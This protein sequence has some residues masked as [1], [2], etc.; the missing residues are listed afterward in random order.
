MGLA[1]SPRKPAQTEKRGPRQRPARRLTAAPRPSGCLSKA[2]A[3]AGPTHVPTS[4]YFQTW[5]THHPLVLC[6]WGSRPELTEKP[7][8][9]LLLQDHS[10]GTPV[11]VDEKMEARLMP[12]SRSRA[13]SRAS[14]LH[15]QAQ[16]CLWGWWG[17]GHIPVTLQ[18]F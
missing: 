17:P 1:R 9:N 11:Q 13:P 8:V 5:D 12:T 4:P 15:L 7:H 14:T 10:L 18:W 3:C 16:I 6:I 2:T